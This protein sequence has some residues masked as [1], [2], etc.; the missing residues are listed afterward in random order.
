M[1]SVIDICNRAL[2]ILGQGTISSLSENTPLAL[3]CNIHWPPIR[4]SL[5][6]EH[7]WNSVS[8]RADLARLTERPA[9]GYKY[10][11]QLPSNCLTVIKTED[12]SFF[13]REG[14]KI[15]SNSEKCQ[16]YYVLDTEDTTLFSPK[17][18]DVAVYKLAAELAYPT[19]K[20]S[21][22]A[23]S[24]L[25]ESKEKLLDAKQVDSFEGKKQD[26]RRNR[27]INAKLS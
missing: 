6:S 22:L 17:L 16:I 5:L 13:E 12:G 23:Q 21:S 26:T 14:G 19:T 25:A 4:Q 10:Y 8:R 24:I 20:S 9:F 27:L 1:A 11:Y 7:T 2:S 18:T 15:L 3:A